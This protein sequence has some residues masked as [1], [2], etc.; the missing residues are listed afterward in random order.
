[1]TSSGTTL[2]APSLADLSFEIFD[3]LQ[4]RSAEVTVDQL[5][6]IRRSFNLVLATWAS[7]GVNL[8]ACELQTVTMPQGVATYAC[9]AST[10]AILPEAFVRTYNLT[11]TNNIAAA[12]TTV[13]GETEVTVEMELNGVEVDSYVNV[14]TP[15]SVG[16]ILISGFY[17]VTSLPTATSFTFEAADAALSS[18]TGGV[19]PYFQTYAANPQ[20][21]VTSADHGQVA[22]GTYT[23]QVQTSV[24]GIILLGQYPIAGVV[25]ADSFILTFPSPALSDDAAYENSGL[26]QILSQQQGQLPVDRVLY[27]ISREEYTSIPVKLQQAPPTSFWFNLTL[28]PTLTVWPVP[29]GQGPY[30]LNYYRLRQLQDANPQGAQTADVPYRFLEALCAG[31][32]AHLA[33]KWK[34]ESYELLKRIADEEWK[35][36][37]DTDREK[38]PFYI[39]GQM[40]GYFR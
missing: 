15:V 35:L 8:W 20:I 33:V 18:E 10:I 9:D 23:V 2:Y 21:T 28:S 6:S 27:P 16:G 25:D 17:L 1:M 22:G 34:P 19:V 36:A 31:V 38:V 37:S 12:F 14:S 11:T 13:V 39:V 26:A 5:R 3:R 32:A 4:L 29:D 30:Q 40:D 7:R 24:G